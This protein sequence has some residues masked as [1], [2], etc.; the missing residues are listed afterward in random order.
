MALVMFSCRA[1]GPFIMFRET[2]ERIFKEI[3]EPFPETGA[4]PAEDLPEML[5]RLEEV[6][7]RDRAIVR[8]QEAEEERRRRTSTYEEEQRRRES[9]EEEE[10]ERQA[11]ERIHLYQR[12]VPLKDM[13]KRAIRHDEAVMWGAP[14][15][16]Y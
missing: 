10:A 5:R 7:A 11:K 13:I 14:Q 15:G 8:A 9:G 16:M 6:E 4:V 2:A 12:V 1:T 3:G